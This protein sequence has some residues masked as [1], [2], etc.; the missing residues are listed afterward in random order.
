MQLVFLLSDK[1]SAPVEV[2]L[3]EGLNRLSFF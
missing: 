3:Q 1:P 2:Q